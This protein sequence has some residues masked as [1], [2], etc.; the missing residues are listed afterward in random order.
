MS[1]IHQH[2]IDFLKVYPNQPIVVAYSGGIDSQVLLFALAQLKQQKLLTNELLVCHINHG[3]SDNALSWQHAAEDFCQ[4]LGLALQ[5][6]QVEVKEVPGESLEALARNARYKALRSYA[7][8][9]ALIMTGHH[10][11]DQ[12]ET[13]LLALKR[14]AGLKGLSAMSEVV[15][16]NH[17]FNSSDHFTTNNNQQLLVRPL[18]N[19]SRKCI[20]NYARE[21]ELTW[22]EDE[23]NNDLRFDRNFI[24]HQIMPLLIKRWPSILTTIKRN[25]EHCQEGQLLLTELAQQDL[26]QCQL[27]STSLSVK[28]LNQLSLARFNNLLRYF[29][30]INHCL[31]PSTKQLQQVNQ[32]LLAATDKMPK[33]KNLL[34]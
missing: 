11:D 1:S 27:S 24:R 34:F 13:F 29:L 10:G 31:M 23:S 8:S 21:H 28:E 2:L 4:Q 32:Q 30:E 9:N 15:K 20:D 6:F 7:A 19:I 14:G 3:L 25:S 16:L 17:S 22:V 5:V 26:G 18:L 33:I 12:S